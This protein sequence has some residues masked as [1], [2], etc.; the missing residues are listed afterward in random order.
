MKV[1]ALT[2]YFVAM[3]AIGVYFYFKSKNDNGEK[4]YF[5]GDVQWVRGLQQ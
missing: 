3:L 5:L 4:E 2:L 1:L